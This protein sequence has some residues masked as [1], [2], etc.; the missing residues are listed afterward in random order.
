MN[1]LRRKVFPIPNMN[2]KLN[3]LV[4]QAK[5]LEGEMLAEIQEGRQK[6]GYELEGRAV[7]FHAAVGAEHRKIA[8]SI[9]RCLLEAKW[10]NIITAPMIWFCVFPILFMDVVA[11]AYQFVCFP[12][13]RIPKVRRKDYVVMDRSRLLYLNSM[14]RFNCAYCGSLS[15]G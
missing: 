5:Q 2:E 13:Y 14:E 1:Q 9:A 11:E 12:I 8:K 3:V 4:A 10:L 6:F 15:S 7:R